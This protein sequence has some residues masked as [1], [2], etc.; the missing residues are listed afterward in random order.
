MTGTDDSTALEGGQRQSAEDR[1]R[2]LEHRKVAQQHAAELG[3]EQKLRSAAEQAQ[4]R[5]AFLAEASRV[6]ASSLDF[7]TTLRNVAKLAVPTVADWC[8]VDLVDADGEL[9]RLAVEHA[10]AAKRDFVLE[11]QRRY[12]PD[13]Q[14]KQGAFEV[15]RTGRT[16]FV[17]R[18]PDELLVASAVDEEHLRLLRG[19][20]L[21]SFVVAPLTGRD[22][23]LGAITFVHSESGRN[24]EDGDVAFL[25]DLARRAATAIENARLV[26]ELEETRQLL[27]E[28]AALLESQTEELH[29]QAAHLEQSQVE[30]ELSNVELQE[31]NAALAAQ[32]EELERQADEK[33]LLLDSVQRAR[34]DEARVADS[35]Q[36]VGHSIAAELDVQRILQDVTD[37]ATELTGAEFGLSVYTIPDPTGSASTLRAVS[38]GELPDIVADFPFTGRRAYRSDDLGRERTLPAWPFADVVITPR[39]LTSFLAVPVVSRTGER[40]G[41][42]FFGHSEAARFGELQERLA[43]GIA[44]WAAV[45]V[46][47][48]RLYQ[49]ER[50]ARA[51]AERANRAKADFLA[52]MSHELRTPLNA[53][54]GYTDLLLAGIPV[55]VPDEARAK[56][57]RIAISARHLLE[58]IEEVLTFARLEA[59]EETIHLETVELDTLLDEVQALSEPL[60]MAK[61]LHFTCRLRP[62]LPPM[63]SDARKLRQI[64][65][66]LISNAIK[67]TDDG[68]VELNADEEGGTIVFRVADT[69]LGIDPG[70]QEKIF[71]PFWQVD[72]GTT[73]KAGGTG[74][75]LTVSR[76][77][78]RLLGGDIELSSNDGAG[79]TFTVRLP[80]VS[81]ARPARSAGELP[82]PHAG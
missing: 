50:Q 12:P 5:M 79:S 32:T 43:M 10:D 30:V 33:Q 68:S 37:A 3:E 67:F 61:G 20:G 55:V 19:L 57:E 54:I 65:L 73:R 2:E 29:L 13:P 26:R 23:V 40:L 63:T 28:Q 48:A 82:A 60:A 71:E 25:E 45:A 8:A 4:Q 78:A 69:G 31:S 34:R 35:I 44:G 38:G 47:N 59:G 70:H 7:E 76:R 66:N 21:R 52:T 18:I 1:L 15:V 72:G 56:I 62:E 51:E 80:R 58:L 36:R 42:L 27:Q 14:S 11:L 39:G 17:E 6:L 16:Q 81:A 53:M 22:G 49:A 24:Y 64:L 75:G 74:L 9:Q 77:L 46:D 41:G